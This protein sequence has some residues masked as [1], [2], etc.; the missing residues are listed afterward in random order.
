MSNWYKKYDCG[1][2]RHC[3]NNLL[4]LRIIDHSRFTASDGSV[5]MLAQIKIF[6]EDHYIPFC[7]FHHEKYRRWTTIYDRSPVNELARKHHDIHIEFFRV[8]SGYNLEDNS[9]EYNTML[10]LMRELDCAHNSRHLERGWY[11]TEP[12]GCPCCSSGRCSNNK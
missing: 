6:I 5:E 7:E 2:P 9:H 1:L 10:K 8:Y 4:S 11:S 3:T 12:T